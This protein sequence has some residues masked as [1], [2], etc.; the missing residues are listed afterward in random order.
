MMMALCSAISLLRVL[1]ETYWNVNDDTITDYTS[2]G[3]VLIETYWNVNAK[4]LN[5][6]SGLTQ[7]LNRNILECKFR[8]AVS[9]S[10]TEYCVLIETYWNVN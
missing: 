7:C 1:I 2:I 5:V 8:L 3:M 10:I 4:E 9:I 6:I